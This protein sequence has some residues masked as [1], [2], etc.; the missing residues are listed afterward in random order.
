MLNLK[1]QLNLTEDKVDFKF[2]LGTPP[3]DEYTPK[4]KSQLTIENNTYG[5]LIMLDIIENMNDGKAYY[6]WNWVAK[7]SD[8]QYNYVLKTDDDAFVY[9]Q[10]LA[11]NLRPLS[12]K[13]LYYRL[14]SP[15]H[16]MFG[17]L[18]VLS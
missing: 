16:F 15:D 14:E 3:Q 13:H 9:F 18:E 6:Y 10:N 12:Q 2:I 4:L 5:D 8:M 7:Y 17:E 1:Q 11:L